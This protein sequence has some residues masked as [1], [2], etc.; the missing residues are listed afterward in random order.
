MKEDLK[1]NSVSD[2]ELNNLDKT[3]N[4]YDRIYIENSVEDTILDKINSILSKYDIPLFLWISEYQKNYSGDLQILKKLTNVKQLDIFV[5]DGEISSLSEIGFI[6]DLQVL[7]LRKY[8]KKGIAL[9]DIKKFSNL[10]H[11]ELENGLNTKQHSFVD[12]LEKLETFAT[13]DFDLEKI[14]TKKSLKNL[15]IYRKILNFEKIVDVFPNLTSLYLEK[16][17][18]LDL[19][20]IGQLPHIQ[21]VWLRY[22]PLVSAI[23]EFI[24][25][26]N[27]KLFQTTHLPK[28]ADV[29]E[30]FKMSNLESLMMTDLSLLK[31]DDFSILSELPNLKTVYI[32]FKE[33]KENLKFFEFCQRNNWIYKQ[34]ALVK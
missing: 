22:M 1:L 32:T 31:A 10:K 28:L 29:S 14:S 20:Y 25:P 24:N 11:F 5:S 9:N 18:D 6:N 17:K 33:P 23:P 19:S 13:F 34:P 4:N 27:I 16:C 12:K 26:G 8:F 2:S 30:I 15:R 7:K 3:I 21:E